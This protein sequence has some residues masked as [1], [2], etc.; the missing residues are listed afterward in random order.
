MT[1][2]AVLIIALMKKLCS[3]SFIVHIVVLKNRIMASLVFG[4]IACSVQYI[5]KLIFL[6]LFLLF[7][8][9]GMRFES[10]DLLQV[11]GD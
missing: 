9:A 3:A 6:Q 10:G 7:R 1:I 4:L 11:F 8:E 5:T 2:R